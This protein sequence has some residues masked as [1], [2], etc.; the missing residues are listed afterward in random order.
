MRCQ[1]TKH[2]SGAATIA[3][4]NPATMARRKNGSS[5]LASLRRAASRLRRIVRCVGDARDIVAVVV[6]MLVDGEGACCFDPEKA[7]VGRMLRHRFRD[8]RA[9]YVAVETD[10]PV[11]ARHDDVQIVRDEQH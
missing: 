8:A 7:R 10:D 3:R 1:T 4:A 6:M 11:A 9:A 2:P 5:T